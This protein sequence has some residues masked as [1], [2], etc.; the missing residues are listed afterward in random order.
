M[1]VFL[2]SFF[3]LFLFFSSFFFFF[4][5][6]VWGGGGLDAVAVVVLCVFLS[7]L[8]V[9]LVFFVLIIGRLVLYFNEELLYLFADAVTGLIFGYA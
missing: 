5:F 1:W 6:F 7:V 3:F 4:F 2:L 9:N 8:F